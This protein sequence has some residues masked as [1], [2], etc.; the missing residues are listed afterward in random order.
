MDRIF[1]LNTV[2]RASN[3]WK[4]IMN[5]ELIKKELEFTNRYFPTDAVSAAQDM[6][7]E[8]TDYFLGVLIEGANDIAPLKAKGQTYMLHLYALF[9]LARWR[10][11]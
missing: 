1:S 8:L 6:Q 10:E 7:A 9:L 3:L 11:P 4:T 2:I 5:I